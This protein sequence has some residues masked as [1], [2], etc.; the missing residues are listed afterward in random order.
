[1]KTISRILSV[2]LGFLSI[3]LFMTA[4]VD[5]DIVIGF[6]VFLGSFIFLCFNVMDEQ[7]EEIEKLK[8]INRKK[9][10]Y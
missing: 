5:N 7:K 3:Y 8:K 9:V 1:M 4:E 6:V 10:V 2:V